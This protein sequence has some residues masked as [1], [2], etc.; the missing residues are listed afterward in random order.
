MEQQAPIGLVEQLTD[1]LLA[2]ALDDVDVSGSTMKFRAEQMAELEAKM[3][4]E[5]QQA[6]SDRAMSLFSECT[7]FASGRPIEHEA[8]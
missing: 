2:D 1:L 4:P 7:H 6:A 5:E 8:Q 3:T